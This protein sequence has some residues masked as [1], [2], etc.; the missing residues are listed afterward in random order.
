MGEHAGYLDR[1]VVRL[2]AFEHQIGIWC[3]RA[4]DPR[5]VRDLEARL[6]VLR[7]RLQLMRRAGREVTT[8]MTQAF[9]QSFERLRADFVR[10]ARTRAA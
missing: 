4:E 7:E 8:E 3:E 1:M 9:T 2:A 5:L 6:A 10:D